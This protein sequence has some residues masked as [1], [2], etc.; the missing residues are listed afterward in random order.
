M[1][2][3]PYIKMCIALCMLMTISFSTVYAA[4][5]NYILNNAPLIPSYT[6]Y[7]KCDNEVQYIL[8]QITT[9]EMSTSQKVKRCYDWII[10]SCT[11]GNSV[12]IFDAN[13][14][15]MNQIEYE[16]AYN[17]F[18]NKVGVCDDYSAAFAV[19]TRAIGLNCRVA[20]GSTERADGGMTGHAWCVMVI[21]GTEYIF[22]PQIDDNIARGGN[23]GYYRYCKRY[24]EVPDSYRFSGYKKEY[25][26][27]APVK[28]HGDINTKDR[29]IDIEC[30][31]YVVLEFPGYQAIYNISNTAITEYLDDEKQ[32]VYLRDPGDCT[33]DVTL[34]KNGALYDKFSI[35]YHIIPNGYIPDF[36]LGKRSISGEE[37]IKSHEGDYAADFFQEINS[38][39]INSNMPPLKLSA[40]L[41]HAARIRAR[42]LEQHYSHLRPD[43]SRY[44]TV[45]PNGDDLKEAVSRFIREPEDVCNNL[46]TQDT[47]SRAVIMDPNIREMG[48]GY[49]NE[50]SA[51]DPMNIHFYCILTR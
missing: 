48:V 44:N 32:I 10:N 38:R 11:Y 45:L 16:R 22:D 42:E 19:L 28:E 21:D 8:N 37:Y 50:V 41:C 18:I 23:I 33:I 15:N 7:T 2:M 34:Y 31:Q 51:D 25:A 1:I 27:I 43:N 17:M 12:K 26:S 29:P 39:R 14:V 20:Y 6:G 13:T 46:M 30:W 24:D 3:K 35:N 47:I 49:F 36:D 9:P 4:D 5:A 40:D